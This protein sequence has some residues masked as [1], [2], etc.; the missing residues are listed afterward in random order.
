M[1]SK[2]GEILSKADILL[3]RGERGNTKKKKRKEAIAYWN[4]N[5]ALKWRQL[6]IVHEYC[7][8][9]HHHHHHTRAKR[10]GDQ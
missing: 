4:D 2:E 1:N 7:P 6:S 8:G 5:Y 10:V 3:K 9:N